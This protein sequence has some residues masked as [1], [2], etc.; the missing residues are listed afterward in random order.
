MTI[1]L[2]KIL[3][4]VVPA[5]VAGCESA[6]DRS[7]G[8]PNDAAEAASDER[9]VVLFVGTSLTAGFGL[10]E[11]EAY[12]AWI[13]R[14]V[15]SL[16]LGY[17]VVNA[18]VSGETSAGGVR[19]IEWLLDQPIAV[20]VVEL[21]ANDALR[22]L[23][24]RALRRN[25]DELIGRARHRHPD[26][27]VVV[28]G[29]EAPPNLGDDYTDAFRRVFEDVADA[30][31]AVL[32]P[33]VLAGVAGDPTLNQSDGIHPTARGQR[34]IAE[35]MWRALRPLLSEGGKDPSS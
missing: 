3:V 33:F 31:D 26:V 7:A 16:N 22:G 29:M 28:A 8:T 5:L 19:R 11:S 1:M 17:R 10:D 24:P 18:G 32:I 30:H 13:R 27:R 23:D 9:P 34:I 4:V 21:G 12:P 25:L 35:T 6:P 15:D 20:L 2:R 14:W